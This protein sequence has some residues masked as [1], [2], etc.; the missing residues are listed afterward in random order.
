[1]ASLAHGPDQSDTETAAT[2]ENSTTT[3]EPRKKRG[4]DRQS[5]HQSFLN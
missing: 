3:R 4:R 1:M 2:T 5:K